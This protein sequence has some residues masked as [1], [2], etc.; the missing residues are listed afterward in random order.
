M[1]N[2]KHTNK[3]LLSS[4]IFITM[5]AIGAFLFLF[6]HFYL[7][8]H[9]MYYSPVSKYNSVDKIMDTWFISIFIIYISYGIFLKSKQARKF[10][11]RHRLSLT[12][13]SILL[14]IAF[15]VSSY[16]LSRFIVLVYSHL[17]IPRTIDL[18]IPPGYFR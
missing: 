1:T 7:S 11:H 9:T 18:S 16:F 14:I 17:F 2:T 13:I 10:I 3:I 15:I 6:N 12:I 5:G 8:T 4:T